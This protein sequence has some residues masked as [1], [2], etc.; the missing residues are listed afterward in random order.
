[1]DAVWK[2]LGGIERRL[3]WLLAFCAALLFFDLGAYHFLSPDEGRYA[4]A[5]REILE[6]RDWVVPHF[7]YAERLNKPPLLYW[8]AAASF[9]VFGPNEWAGRVVPALAALLGAVVLLRLGRSMG[10][11]TDGRLAAVIL[12]TSPWYFVLAR[13]LI[14]DMLL[15]LWLTL[16]L[17][18]FW[19][20]LHSGRTRDYVLFWIAAAGA[21]LTKGPAGVALPG[22]IA[23]LYL[24]V[25]RQWPQ[26]RWKPLLGTFCLFPALALPWFAAAEIRKPGFLAYFLFSENVARFGGKYHSVEPFYFYLPV[27]AV[28]LLPWTFTLVPALLR[29]V[30]Q[31]RHREADSAELF[32]WIW[33]GTF[34]IFFSLSRAKLPTYILPCFPPLALL[35]ARQWAGC[36]GADVV[37]ARWPRRA[38]AATCVTL[39][40]LLLAGIFV[41]RVLNG[42]GG[43]DRAALTASVVA[44]TLVGVL[45]VGVA[46][47]RKAAVGPLFAATALAATVFLAGS[48]RAASVILRAEDVAPLAEA[49]SR[50]AGLEDRVILYDASKM[51]A[52]R[53]YYG[54][55]HGTGTRRLIDLPHTVLPGTLAEGA[56]DEVRLTPEERRAGQ[57]QLVAA[58]RGPDRTFCLIKKQALSKLRRDFPELPPLRG[59]GETRKYILVVNAATR[60][61]PPALPQE[62]ASLPERENR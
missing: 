17:A 16:T 61:N 21:T 52:F 1:M 43:A 29:F 10:R 46:L 7:A 56:G 20:A 30:R 12:L 27:L 11:D 34:F 19:W 28:G 25:N 8:L 31:L 42:L 58:L 48:V 51:T 40:L 59:L 23:V 4:E 14:T 55:A 13:T 41:P 62:R 3:G 38:A 57:Q 24:T 36:F 26:V 22:L 33:A 15:C 6:L 9:Q 49:A 54:L 60:G 2:S 18:A 32:L 35:A 44:A 39:V 5:A 37:A 50:K 53:F 47:V 45:L